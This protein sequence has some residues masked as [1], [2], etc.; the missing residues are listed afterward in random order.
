M[1]SVPRSQPRLRL[2]RAT[3]LLPDIRHAVKRDTHVVTVRG[4]LDIYSSSSLEDELRKVKGSVR[5]VV[6]FSECRYI[7]SSVITVLIHARKQRPNM[8]VVAALNGQVRKILTMT[9]LSNAI[10]VMATIEEAE[11]LGA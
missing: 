9:N 7:D 11:K 1:L 3:L 8:R 5:L 6:D 10:P 2:K 4:E